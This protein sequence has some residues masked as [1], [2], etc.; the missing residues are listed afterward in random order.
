MN[1]F[2]NDVKDAKIFKKIF[3]IDSPVKNVERYY[4]RKPDSSKLSFSV[5][6]NFLSRKLLNGSIILDVKVTSENE[7]P[8]ECYYNSGLSADINK[9]FC[10]FGLTSKVLYPNKEETFTVKIK[11]SNLVKGKIYPL[12]MQCYSLPKFLYRYE[13]TGIFNPYSYL[14]DDSIKEQ[15]VKN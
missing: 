9:K 6:E 5:S 1:D 2:I 14:N 15:N 3:G 13:T 4:D 8:I 10:I 7:E 12:N 11:K